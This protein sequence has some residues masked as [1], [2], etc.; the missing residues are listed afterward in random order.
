MLL[1]DEIFYKDVLS[2]LGEQSFPESVRMILILNPQGS[3]EE[4]PLTL[5]ESF[6]HITLTTPYRS[7]IAITRLARFIAKSRGLVVP[8]G[9]FGSDVEGTKP[10][11]F[12]VGDDGRKRKEAL[13]H[14]HKHLGEKS[15]SSVIGLS[16]PSQ[17]QSR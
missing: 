7:T 12:D 9:D 8:E 16:F 6:L 2:K 4:N 15:P 14:C 11:F 5:P 10:I 13:E 1:V 17:I 3:S